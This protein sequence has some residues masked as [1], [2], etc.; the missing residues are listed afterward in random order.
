ML[1][2]SGWN[3]QYAL[4]CLL[5]GGRRFQVELPLY[6]LWQQDRAALDRFF[7][8]GKAEP[9]SFWIRSIAA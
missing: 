8:R 5:S 2:R 1:F 9:H 3:E 4:E 7:P 6:C